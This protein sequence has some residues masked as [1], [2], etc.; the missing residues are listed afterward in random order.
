MQT[1]LLDAAQAVAWV[2][3]RYVEQVVT[4]TKVVLGTKE[5]PKPA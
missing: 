2:Q 4:N 3:Y 5:L 1:V